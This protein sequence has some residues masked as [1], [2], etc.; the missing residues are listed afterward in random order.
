[1]YYKL[2][3]MIDQHI[4]YLIEV[5]T[6]RILFLQFKKTGIECDLFYY[7]EFLFTF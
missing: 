6:N 7:L 3:V 5:F 1:M 4:I 2:V